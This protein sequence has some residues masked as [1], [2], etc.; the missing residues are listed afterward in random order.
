MGLV[1]F[2]FQKVFDK[3]P[4]KNLVCKKYKHM[5]LE[6]MSW[7]GLKQQTVKI[8]ETFLGYQEFSV[9]CMDS[10]LRNATVLYYR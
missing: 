2:L 8:N 5:E 4:D 9:H 7:T 1:Y 10:F 6:V 3:A